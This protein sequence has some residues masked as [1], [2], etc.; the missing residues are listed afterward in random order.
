M[1]VY[2][3]GRDFLARNV[4]ITPISVSVKPGKKKKRH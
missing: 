4:G 1:S 3:R 2:I